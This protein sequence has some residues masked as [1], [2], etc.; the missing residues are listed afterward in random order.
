MD[1]RPVLFASAGKL[2]FGER[3]VHCSP[4]SIDA[5]VAVVTRHLKVMLPEMWL[6]PYHP[7][8][9]TKSARRLRKR[10]IVAMVMAGLALMGTA[11]ILAPAVPR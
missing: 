3:Q 5:G 4:Q 2:C 1:P 9:G 11:L 10:V 6:R 8:Q 7:L